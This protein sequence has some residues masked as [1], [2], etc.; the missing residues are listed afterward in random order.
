MA[1]FLLIYFSKHMPTVSLAYLNLSDF[2]S[3]QY[4]ENELTSGLPCLFLASAETLS[5]TY[6]LKP[7]KVFL[8]PSSS[9]R[10]TLPNLWRPIVFIFQSVVKI[11]FSVLNLTLCDIVIKSLSKNCLK[12]KN[13][14]LYTYIFQST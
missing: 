10:G 9:F 14:N 13:Y 5:I 4:P 7:L 3:P 11:C 12:H 1:L 8:P 2:E 6:L